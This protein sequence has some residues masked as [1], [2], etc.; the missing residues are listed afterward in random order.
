MRNL[1]DCQAQMYSCPYE[2]KWNTQLSQH[3][4]DKAGAKI[5]ND[6]ILQGLA[7]D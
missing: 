7:H 5:P 2:N 3:K 1:C 4:F 6:D